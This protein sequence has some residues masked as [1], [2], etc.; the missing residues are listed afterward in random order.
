MTEELLSAI[1]HDSL[2]KLK[3][4]LTTNEFDLNQEVESDYGYDLEDPD[5]THILFY[6]TYVDASM[7]AVEMLIEHGADIEYVNSDGV[8]L[9]DTAIKHKRPDIVELCVNN[10]LDISKSRRKSGITPLILASTFNDVEMVKYLVKQ[11]ASIDERDN[12]GQRAIDYATKMDQK[13]IIEYIK[14]LE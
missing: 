6:A 14:S 10:G 3:K 5:S 1:E 13:A 8:G 4:L 11:G 7:E 2:V 9:I 12:Y